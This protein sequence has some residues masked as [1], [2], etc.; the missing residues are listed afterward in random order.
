MADPSTR[1]VSS[2]ISESR[3]SPTVKVMQELTAQ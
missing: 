2:A 1:K 3:L